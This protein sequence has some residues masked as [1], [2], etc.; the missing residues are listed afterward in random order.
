MGGKGT[1]RSCVAAMVLA[2]TAPAW[3]GA[4]DRIEVERPPVRLIAPA[5]LGPERAEALADGALDALLAAA[6][7]WN[8]PAPPVTVVV[9]G[10]DDRFAAWAEPVPGPLVV[11]PVLRAWPHQVGGG[12]DDPTRLLLVHEMTHA[13][14]LAGRSPSVPVTL[15]ITGAHVPWPPPAWLLEGVAVWTESRLLGERAGRL[16]DPSA[17]AVLRRLALGSGWPELDDAALIT[18]DAWPA[19]QVRYLAGGVL[20]ERMIEEAGHDA[21]LAALRR[22]ETQAPWLG[23]VHA[24]RETTGRDLRATW[25]T[26]GEEL[27]VEA[28]AHSDDAGP[29]V[30][31][32]AHPASSPDGRWLAWARGTDL[33]LAR[34]SLDGGDL[35]EPVVLASLPSAPTALRWWNDRALIGLRPVDGPRGMRHEPFEVRWGTAGSDGRASG[36][37]L[38]SAGATVR[39]WT[40]GARARAVVPWRGAP[41]GPAGACL[42]WLREE[43]PGASGLVR[44]CPSEPAPDGDREA[45]IGAS[46]GRPGSPPDDD[47]ATRLVLRPTPGSRF[48]GADVA[49]DGVVHV[50]EDRDGV[51]SW[52]PV[53]PRAAGVAADGAG[54]DAADTNG[55]GTDAPTPT[56][57]PEGRLR[58]ALG[59][60]LALPGTNVREVRF[61]ADGGLGWL[62]GD[63]D[64]HDAVWFAPAG[65][66]AW[67]DATD[68]SVAVG[69]DL[70]RARVVA[71]PL[72]G[73]ISL[74]ADGSDAWWIGSRGPDGA[75]VLRVAGVAPSLRPGA[76]EPDGPA[77]ATSAVTSPAERSPAPASLRADPV[78]ARPYHPVR[79]A[80]LLGWRPTVLADGGPAVRVDAVDSTRT[81]GAEVQAGLARRADGPW[82]RAAL[83]LTLRVGDV[84]PIPS[85][86]LP[87]PATARLTVG[88][89][90]FAPHRS[91]VTGPRMRFEAALGTTVAYEPRVSVGVTAG[92]V[93]DASG[94]ARPTGSA[95]LATGVGRSDAWG[96]PREGMAFAARWRSDPL[97][98]GGR[99]SGA[100][101]D[102]SR[103]WSWIPAAGPRVGW[104]ASLHGRAGWRAPA[105][106]PVPGW[107]D[108]AATVRSGVRATIPV[109]WRLADGRYA[110]ERLRLEPVLHLAWAPGGSAPLAWGAELRAYADLVLG[111]GAP[112]SLGVRAG[113][114]SDRAGSPVGFVRWAL[115]ALP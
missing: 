71:R 55:A 6:A 48:V 103:W 45:G 82:G 75:E 111:Y 70:R 104:G 57:G 27:R 85:P 115:P 42:A 33:Y 52:R 86:A 90:P 9:R 100:W 32:G 67:N 25:R 16:D 11:V 114:A 18:H 5:H 39:T 105:I 110:W 109:R 97:P 65:E 54:T 72:G 63:G 3:A 68:R 92:W 89:L 15:G 98:G 47:A 69:A 28:E 94:R 17:R 41:G 83:A 46:P 14:H 4:N 61:A 84:R 62:A 76:V 23:F 80:R 95:S 53:V 22:F 88:V 59:P 49:P 64:G 96:V 81:F 77:S 10:E 106:L 43:G 1:F 34:R 12:S 24:W 13:V 29:V 51:R 107:D 99:S 91:A 21:F 58:W 113:V 19:G 78:E 20:V 79:G 26:L 108:A 60:G 8:V 31:L 66:G 44:F 101:L 36:A 30:T 7:F 38:V 2:L 56:A 50:L 73:A 93:V 35:H 112:V 87:A 37:A 74:A 102:G 40:V